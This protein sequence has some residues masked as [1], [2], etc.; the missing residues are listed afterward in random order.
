MQKQFRQI[1]GNKDL[2]IRGLI[3]SRII[4]LSELS[5]LNLVKK[6]CF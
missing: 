3:I 1:K 5:K 2:L 6:P 4:C